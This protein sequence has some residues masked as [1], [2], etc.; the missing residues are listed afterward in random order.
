LEFKKILNYYTSKIDM[1]D[2]E[3][4][5]RFVI[6]I[7]LIFPSIGYAQFCSNA[8][9]PPV[10][11][12]GINVTATFTG[13]VSIYP[14]AYTS[15]GLYT[16]P[17]NSIHLGQSGIY[18]YTMNFS[19]PVNNLDFVI[20]A[21]GE[22]SNE[23]F[24]FTT[25][26]G[27]PSIIDQGSCFSTIIGNVISSGLLATSSGGGGNFT[28]NNS[29]P[30]S[31]VTISGP[32]GSAGSLFAFCAS[33][34]VIAAD[35]TIEICNGDSVL[36][37]G[38]YQSVS[39]LYSDG[40][41]NINLIVN[42]IPTINLGNDTTLCQAE[43]LTLDAT[44][45][46]ATYLWQDNSTNPTFNVIQQGTYWVEVTVNNC[47]TANVILINQEDCEIILELPNIFT[48]NND[49]INDLFIP[50]KR[51][52]IISIST[53]IYNRWG[54]LIFTSNFLEI[55]WDG[56]TTSGSLVPYGTYFWIIDY[57]DINGVENNLKG[58]ITILK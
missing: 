44:T 19:S 5:L 43:S 20:T 15:C 52:G 51:I 9:V 3:Y 47:S 23:V 38:T 18:S 34:I 29:I 54:Q 40:F 22:N 55:G 48:P 27:V 21:T 7:I 41:Y 56:R 36:I 13:S 14:S 49:G 2:K 10:T 57:T 45:P 26:T 33:S 35:S 46:N 31:S 1:I 24:T 16:T 4:L 37:G 17:T 30:F 50:I 8:V 58:H 32:G 39:G 28:L 11:I 25:N 6:W 53:K 42:A 12:N